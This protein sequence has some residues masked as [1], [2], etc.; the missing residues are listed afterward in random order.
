ME[1]KQFWKKQKEYP[2]F[3]NTK[4]RR[5]YELNYLVP[6]LKKTKSILD[7]GCGDGSLIKC[8][9][10]LTDIKKYYAYD[11]SNNL[12][13]HIPDKVTKKEYDIYSFESLPKTEV[14]IMS[15]VSYCIFEDDIIENLLNNIE[16]DILYIRDPLT[17]KNKRENIRT[18]SKKLKSEY[19]A[20]Y[21][22]ISEYI[23][24]LKNWKI[25]E[26]NRIYPDSIESKFGTKQFYFKCIRKK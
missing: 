5:L 14:T 18:Y 17:L 19:A 1:S 6:H 10:E 9:M 3:G 20:C 25:T 24:M 13:K 26:I 7:L 2:D 12:M 11:I 8:L 21:R 22:T 4:E 23:K 16:S 15:G